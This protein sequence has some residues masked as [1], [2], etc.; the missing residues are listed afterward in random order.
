[1][2]SN[3]N[4]MNQMPLPGTQPKSGGIGAVIAVVIIIALL[5]FGAWYFW[6]EV[7]ERKAMTNNQMNGELQS[8]ST[9][10]MTAELDADLKA[11]QNDD[12]GQSDEAQVD[13]EFKQ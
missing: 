7:Q 11:M 3:E 10:G 1:M 4:Y 8:T 2:N 9:Q 13:N 6:N 12:V 5:A